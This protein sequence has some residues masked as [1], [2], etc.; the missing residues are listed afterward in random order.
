MA[1]RKKPMIKEHFSVT[2][3]VTPWARRWL[4]NWRE[5][6]AVAVFESTADQS[7]AQKFLLNRRAMPIGAVLEE[8]FVAID[9]TGMEPAKKARPPL[10]H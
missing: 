3:S 7:D 4:Q 8:L 10:A 1:K 5:R 2:I 9:D 6:A